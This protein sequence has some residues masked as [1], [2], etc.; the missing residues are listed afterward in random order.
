[1]HAATIDTTT[2]IGARGEEIGTCMASPGSTKLAH[3][4]GF[5]HRKEPV[6]IEGIALQVQR[7]VA[8]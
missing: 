7:I 4:C 2:A 8:M 3:L 5:T 1:M 6:E